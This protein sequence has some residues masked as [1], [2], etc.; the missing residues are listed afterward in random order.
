[1]ASMPSNLRREWILWGTLIAAALTIRLLAAAWWQAKLGSPDGFA[2]GDSDSY[3]V[4]GLAISRGGPFEYIGPET[5]LM[6]MPG[7]PFVL[8][9][10]FFV[11][12]GEL[13]VFWARALGGVLGVAAVV[14]V[15]LLTRHL[16][17]AREGWAAGGLATVYPGAI[18][19]SVFVLSEALF[20]PLLVGQ[21]SC[22]T[23]ALRCERSPTRLSWSLATGLFSGLA[24][25]SRPS[26]L[27]FPIF[28]GVLGWLIALLWQRD[29]AARHIKV[30]FVVLG[31]TALIM[32]PWWWRSYRISGHFVLTTL[33]MG[34][35]LYDGLSPT[36]DGG[37]DMEFKKSFAKA[38]AEETSNATPGEYAYLLDRRM[39]T[40]AIDWVK[41]NPAAAVDLAV[42][43]LI[44][45]WRPWPNEG[46]MRSTT[47]RCVI[48]V[49]FLPLF[50][51][52]LWGGRAGLSSRRSAVVMLAAPAVY[53]TL[54]HLVF[55]GSI[56]YRQ[57]AMML[58]CVLA[59]AA[60]VQISD[61]FGFRFGRSPDNPKSEDA[62]RGGASE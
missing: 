7:Y 10:M 60:L 16:F 43:K 37:S 3:W 34:A 57:P 29:T 44:R 27:L 24:V 18:A 17:G 32:T 1:M 8:A 33:E 61:R 6:R 21:V 19:M 50:A 40:A 41:R 54:L 9:G 15:T 23:R 22:W 35:S 47:M 20:C 28:V 51:L 36:A 46:K 13:G 4:L 62:G 55:V 56:R 25:M 30:G 49:G 39:K 48:A 59:G 53:I 12:G 52:A 14:G 5:Q 11:G 31:V 38:Q 26:W 2:F 58:S 42:Q 45:V